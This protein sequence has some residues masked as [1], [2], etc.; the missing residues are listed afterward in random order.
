MPPRMKGDMRPRI[1][2]PAVRVAI[3]APVTAPSSSHSSPSQIHL[4]VRF[5]PR[6]SRSSTMQPCT[7][8]S[9]RAMSAISSSGASG[10]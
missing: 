1:Q 5:I 10:S 3:D 9:S 2:K 4:P 6:R 7:G 8:H